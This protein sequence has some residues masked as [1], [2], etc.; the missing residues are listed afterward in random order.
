[1]DGR[2]E[3]VHVDHERYEHTGC[4]CAIEHHDRAHSHDGSGGQ[5]GERINAREIN[6]DHGLRLH[7][8]PPIFQRTMRETLDIGVLLVVHLRGADAIN[9]LLKIRIY[10]RNLA[11]SLRIQP[12][13]NPP[14]NHRGHNDNG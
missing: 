13:R 10:R 9:Q 1:M 12:R 14:E 6:G 5:F 3:E 8:Q 2:E 11:A 4:H 7:T